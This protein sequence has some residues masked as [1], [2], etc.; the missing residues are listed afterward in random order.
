MTPVV[1]AR[2]GIKAT[3][4]PLDPDA[5][6]YETGTRE[7]WQSRLVTSDGREIGPV[8]RQVVE[9]GMYTIRYFVVYDLEQDRHVLVPANTVTDITST[10]VHINVSAEH[11][12]QIPPFRRE[13]D[14]GFEESVYHALGRTPHWVEEARFQGS[15][16]DGPSGDE[17]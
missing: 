15:S 13:M 6:L 14:R 10:H 7:V 17:E 8:I 9:P 12:R 4:V 2:K 5:T 1:K 11:I 3:V 16:G